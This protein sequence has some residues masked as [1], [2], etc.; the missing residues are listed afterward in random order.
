MSWSAEAFLVY[1]TPSVLCG[2]LYSKIHTCAN[3]FLCGILIKQY[4]KHFFIQVFAGIVMNIIGIAV[5]TLAVNTWAE[6]IFGLDTIPEMF[7]N[8]SSSTNKACIQL[9]PN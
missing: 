8:M 3:K 1:M 5:L 6:P 2:F 4:N 9:C 7:Q